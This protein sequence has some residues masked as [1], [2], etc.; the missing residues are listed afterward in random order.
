MRWEPVQLGYGVHR[1][2]EAA[3]HA[4][5]L[6]IKNLGDKCVLKLDFKNAFNS[7][8]RDKMLE[9][10]QSFAP[11]LFPFVHSVYSSPSKLFWEDKI[12]ESAEG[13]QQGDPLGPLLFCLTIHQLC[14]RMKSE[15]SLFYLD[16]GTLGGKVEDVLYMIWIW[17]SVRVL[18][19]V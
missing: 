6:Y 2:A 19:W 4:A 10:V 11:S 13:V 7:V 14:S 9:A 1:G 18:N 8:R 17:W 16:D 5:S 3:V 15:L 12:I